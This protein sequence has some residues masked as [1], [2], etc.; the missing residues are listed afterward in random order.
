M[1]SLYF[2]ALGFT[3]LICLGGC[4]K[5]DSG[6][7]W[8]DEWNEDAVYYS[9]DTNF[10]NIFSPGNKDSYWIFYDSTRQIYDTFVNIGT[11]NYFAG[12]SG[13]DYYYNGREQRFFT[14]SGFDFMYVTGLR[15]GGNPHFINF[16]D[17]KIGGGVTIYRYSDGSYG[18]KGSQPDSEEK[19]KILNEFVI[20]GTT[21]HNVVQFKDVCIQIPEIIFASNIGII[22]M[23]LNGGDNYPSNYY[24]LKEYNLTPIPDFVKPR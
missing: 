2:I 7:T 24:Y 15:N 12:T 3:L 16:F 20:D 17:R 23:E 4:K 5:K 8:G 21:Y 18:R 6:Y 13:A 14:N 11:A 22:Y 9:I 10:S 1:K 19:D